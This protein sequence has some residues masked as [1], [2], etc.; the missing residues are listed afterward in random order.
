MYNIEQRDDQ[1]TDTEAGI[2]YRFT[3]ARAG[4]H[5]LEIHLEVDEPGD[6]VVLAIPNWIPGSYKIRD[7]ISFHGN[8]V[9]YDDDG[10][11]LPFE[12][13]ERNR[14]RIQ[15]GGTLTLHV[16]YVYFGNERSVRTTHVN[17]AHAFVNP[18][19]VLMMVEGR[20]SELHHV[21]IVAPWKTVTT[22]LSPVREG[23][24]GA[25]NYD[26][27]VDS[28]IEIGD[29]VVVQ[30]ERHGSL[31]EIAIT[32]SG[33]FEPE[34]IVER[35]KTIVDQ[36]LA[37]WGALPYDRY[38]FIIQLLPNEYGGLE[39]ARSSVNMFESDCFDDTDRVVGLLTLLCHEY[40][41]L[42][43]VKRIRPIELGPFDYQRENYTRMLWLAEGVTSYYD[44]VMAY[45]C[46]FLNRDAFFKTL[47]AL[48]LQKLLDVPGRMEMSVKDSSY[49]SWVKLYVPTAD[50]HNRFPSYYLK[51]GIIF[52]L[53]DLHIIAE[54]NGERSLDDGMRALWRR[55]L[56]NPSTG[57]TQ[58]E[59]IDIV[60][61]A[62]GV[63][64]GS[65][66][67][68]WI[69]TTAELPVSDVASRLGLAWRSIDSGDR[70]S[71]FGDGVE[72]HPVG[73]SDRWIGMTIEENEKGLRVGRVWSD[74][75]AEAAGVG[76]GDEIVAVDDM[77]VVA[78]K[79]F[80]VAL[81][82][83][84]HRESVE[85]LCASERS[86]YRTRVHFTRRKTFELVA[87]DDA[88]EMELRCRE[89]WLRRSDEIELGVV[90]PSSGRG[91]G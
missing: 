82:A 72:R 50:S 36:G 34:W 80:N 91:V 39:H 74:S 69:S 43:N 38:V 2:R 25:L 14:V 79:E 71:T 1:L 28:P 17:R 8:V 73:P 3:F 4:S 76:A 30:Y 81:R 6:S 59:F 78:S 40:F 9:P 47:A 12:W 65:M 32:G 5:L 22:A 60:S 13:I 20:T 55:Y 42:W 11:P 31:H 10:H 23:V 45:R 33:D 24:W 41:H 46:G 57:V 66:L 90:A 49:L 15:T 61:N 67:L 26:I 18:A 87:L 88:G 53:L 48:H 85:L 21:H 58:D 44:D 29:H 35:T 86:I 83:A 7:F 56:D 64:I 68:P 75:P 89:R 63:N 54:T 51:G 16:E 37:M 77:R 19:N 52:L 70:Q 27:L 62:T 84:R